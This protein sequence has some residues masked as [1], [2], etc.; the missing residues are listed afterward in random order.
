M[1]AIIPTLALLIAGCVSDDRGDRL[2]AY[3][4]S[5]SAPALA[6]TLQGDLD[7]DGRVDQTDLDIVLASWGQRGAAVT[8]SRADVNED[9]SVDQDDLDYVLANWSSGIVFELGP[10]V[11]YCTFGYYG[12]VRFVS[13]DGGILEYTPGPNFPGYDSLFYGLRGDT[14]VP[15][16]ERIYRIGE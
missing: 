2:R 7:S 12:S 11:T 1:R 3:A 4:T 14:D 10:G 8:D 5:S 13:P 9:G 16:W 15:P 6:Y